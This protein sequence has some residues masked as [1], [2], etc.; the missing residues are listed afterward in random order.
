MNILLLNL[1]ILL[2]TFGQGGGLTGPEASVSHVTFR[3][4]HKNVPN[5]RE[6]LQGY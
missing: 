2:F 6:T 3:F 1:H 4:E 5:L